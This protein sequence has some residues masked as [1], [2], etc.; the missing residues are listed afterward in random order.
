MSAPGPAAGRRRARRLVNRR[1]AVPAALAA[2]ALGAAASGVVVQR[3]D[4]K[5]TSVQAAAPTTAAASSL[6]FD[7]QSAP[8]DV[9][10]SQAV[11]T[12][13][14]GTF[15]ALSTA[16]GTHGVDIGAA[17]QS[18]YRST[19]GLHWTASA[20]TDSW[21]TSLGEHDG[22]L[23]AL[24]TAPG[25]NA[26]GVVPQ[27][28]RSTDGGDSWDRVTL[29][30]TAQ[31]PAANVP[32][33][34]GGTIPQLAVHDGVL[35]ASVRTSYYFDIQAAIGESPLS[36]NFGL[37]TAAGIEVYEQPCLAKSER[38]APATFVA[39]GPSGTCTEEPATPIR[40]VPWSEIGISGMDDLT[41]NESFVSRDNGATWEATQGPSAAGASVDVT[42]TDAGFFATTTKY[43]N[44]GTGQLVESRVY[45]S[46]DGVSWH[47]ITPN[48]GEVRYVGVVGSKLVAVTGSGSLTVATSDDGGATWS[49]SDLAPLTNAGSD[50]RVD[51]SV[52]DSGPL[53]IAI[54]AYGEPLDDD[55]V[56]Y[57]NTPPP[58][59]MWLLTSTDATS[60]TV[61]P[62]SEIGDG[63][64]K[65]VNW[66]AVGNDQVVFGGGH[67]GDAT[68][69]QTTEVYVGTPRR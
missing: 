43:D 69:K 3:D 4:D 62:F 45:R 28:G 15:Y 23:Y 8:G 21:I 61:D 24:G 40:T 17:P 52:V 36:N 59:S 9:L 6:E 63:R 38:D 30:T 18:V 1:R 46:D 57:E 25:T 42:S 56:A 58:I 27:L 50:M 49:S 13:S 48:I 11:V 5:A 14:D 22:T 68:T 29:P 67:G 31:P 39:P 54:A 19:D 32:I 26:N 33:E 34:F 2:T 66:L 7:G 44:Y 35:L 53:G 60:W 16:P 41:V 55:K 12:G 10:Y 65:W 51:V 37:P 47:D 64:A 20:S